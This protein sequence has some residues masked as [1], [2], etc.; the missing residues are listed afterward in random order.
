MDLFTNFGIQDLAQPTR[1]QHSASLRL[2]SAPLRQPAAVV[3]SEA[4]PPRQ[5]EPD[6][7]DSEAALPLPRLEAQ[8][9]LLPVVSSV[10]QNQPHSDQL[11]QAACLDLEE[12]YQG[13]LEHP[14][15]RLGLVRALHPPLEVAPM[16]RT[17]E[18]ARSHSQNSRKK[19]PLPRTQPTATKLSLRLILTSN[20]R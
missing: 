3:F 1:L 13:A 15:L 20:G 19:I 14:P 12:Q 5:Q 9:R 18:L 11:T 6:L 17:K 8:R 10:K 7:E 2:D 16:L 4:I